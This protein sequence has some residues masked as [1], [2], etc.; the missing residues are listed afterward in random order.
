MKRPESCKAN[1]DCKTQILI[2]LHG[3]LNNFEF[4]VKGAEEELEK[5]E[6]EEETRG[7]LITT[8]YSFIGEAEH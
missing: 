5:M 6:E 7:A 2:F 1:E 3:G 4:S 8:R